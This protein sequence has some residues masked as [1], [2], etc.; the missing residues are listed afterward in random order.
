MDGAPATAL[1]VRLSP[2]LL[3]TALL[4]SFIWSSWWYPGWYIGGAIAAV[5]IAAVVRSGGLRTE[6]LPLALLFVIV[7]FA[8]LLS[9]ALW[10]NDPR[11]TIKWVIADS[12]EIVVFVLFFLAARN[13]SADEVAIAIASLIVPTL[14]LASVEYALD[15]YARRLAGNALAL[16][17]LVMAFSRRKWP[18][19]VAM[20]CT[21]AYLLIGRSRIPL[22]AA[23][24]AAGLVVLVRGS[25]A[26]DRVRNLA[27]AMA[28]GA[29]IVTAIAIIPATRLMM[30]TTVLRVVRELPAPVLYARME[31]Q[32]DG[33]PYREHLRPLPI[34]ASISVLSERLARESFPLGIGYRN[35]ALRYQEAY[36]ERIPL[37]SMYSAWLIEGGLPV[38][39]YVVVSAGWLV[40]MLRRERGP[41]LIGLAAVLLIGAFH[42]MHQSPAL[43]VLVGLGA[44][45]ATSG[46]RARTTGNESRAPS[47]DPPTPR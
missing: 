22:A 35:F 37:H 38:V 15:P 31:E 6:G 5:A 46:R 12:I 3:G 25:S 16:M 47:W 23:I 39:L 14:M 36:G 29:V 18:Y 7:Y 43:W 20:S 45:A 17:P 2:L 34:R 10:A 33:T 8:L 1:T 26:R 24:L 13:C 42:Q 30:M 44:A 32:L 21:F 11:E 28:I 41:I 19:A 4:W 40:M 9:T 27:A